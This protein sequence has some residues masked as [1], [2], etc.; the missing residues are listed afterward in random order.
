MNKIYTIT[1]I[2]LPKEYFDIG[3]I[4]DEEYSKLD[5]K[6]V[7]TRCIGWYDTVE[8]AKRIVEGNVM[9]IS[10]DGYYNMVVIEDVERGL[11][12]P[13][14]NE[15]WYELKDNKYVPCDKPKYYDKVVCFGI[16]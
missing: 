10:E 15:L 1:T 5:K 13:A 7:R 16:G 4:D 14:D 9:D 6:K 8:E 11:W 12:M 2:K 3:W